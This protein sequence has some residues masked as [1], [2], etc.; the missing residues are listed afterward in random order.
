[1]LRINEYTANKLI[2]SYDARHE[3]MMPHQ[4]EAMY[5][6]RCIC[7]NA[8]SVASY[9]GATPDIIIP[10]SLVEVMSTIAYEGKL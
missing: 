6:V 7:E 2:E 9:L 8:I 5:K 3:T 1:M 10:S 4:A